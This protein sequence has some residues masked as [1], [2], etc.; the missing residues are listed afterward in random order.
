[1]PSRRR[2]RILA[3]QA[4]YSWEASSSFWGLGLG[5]DPDADP[6]PA[7]GTVPSLFP[8]EPPEPPESLG[9]LLEFPW[10]ETAPE[11]RVLDFSRLL[12]RGTI[13]RIGE[14]DAMIRSHLENWDLCR[15][16]RVD[17]A[18]LRMSVYSL[19][20]QQDIA[21]PSIVIAEAIGICREYGTDESFRFVNG[22]LDS[23]R[24]TIKNRARPAALEYAAGSGPK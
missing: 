13:E 8:P 24:R 3:F 11:P 7:P 18:I 1:V 5:L 9:E 15:L 17:L 10:L 6:D 14:V 2:G 19:M 16:N 21:H 23:I 4:L 12:I 22:V 20:Y